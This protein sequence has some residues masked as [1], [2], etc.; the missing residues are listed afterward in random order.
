MRVVPTGATVVLEW[1]TGGCLALVRSD[2]SSADHQRDR[3]R[4]L[5]ELEEDGVLEAEDG[6]GV[7]LRGTGD[8]GLRAS[9]RLLHLAG[10]DE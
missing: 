6:A 4:L 9:H 8:S 10:W 2:V 7:G 3:D 5:A 1:E